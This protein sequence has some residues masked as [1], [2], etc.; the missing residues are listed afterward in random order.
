MSLEIRKTSQWWYGRWTVNGKVYCKNLGIKIAGK[1]PGSLTEEGDRRFE[2]SRARAQAEQDRLR[3]D[4]NDKK[5]TEELLQTIHEIRTG[6]RVGLIALADLPDEWNK[7]P[8]K[9]KP[10]ERYASQCCSTLARFVSFTQD[11]FPAVEELAQ[12]NPKMVKA[13]LQA[14]EDRG[15]TGKTWNDVLKLL[16]A[17]F[18][19]LRRDAGMV[20]NPFEN[21]P[22]KD[23]ETVFRKPF[24]P[25]ELK[26]IIKAAEHDDFIRPII[27]TGICTAMRRGDC[28]MLMWSDV[29]LDNRFIRVKTA[30]TGQ[31]VEI[32]M[33]PMLFEEISRRDRH[34]NE[35]VF[36]EQATMY[37]SNPDGITW[38]VQKVFTA[39]G[40][41]DPK[42]KE[43][44]HG[45]V[46]GETHASRKTGL[47]LASIRD[48]H[49]F[50][51]T[52][53][54]LALTAGV[55]L[56]I[57][58]KVTGHKTTDIVLKHYFQPGREQFRQALQS[59]MPELL[60]N[61]S[62]RKEDRLLALVKDMNAKNWRRTGD[63]LIKIL[64]G[65]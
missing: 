36:P 51:V 23:T 13:F 28:C 33:F 35:Y 16:R 32:P 46:F 63:Q 10:N 47:R 20:D 31:V 34:S 52:W 29:D 5:H 56:E 12:I 53:V 55:K 21:I 27:A 65:D 48:F 62:V 15:V 59:S 26:A 11:H 44:P 42:K 38:R 61:G 37:Q 50:R 57:V 2:Q 3:N 25:E 8:R 39:A 19:R 7:I 41:K 30:K 40:F 14:E 6:D 64:D 17:T 18:K 49:S 22:T 4:A 54:T 60:T 45:S 43:N 9:H 24:T 1:R 58:Q